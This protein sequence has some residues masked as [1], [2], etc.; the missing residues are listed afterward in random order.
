M[1]K[2]IKKGLGPKDSVFF[3]F[4]FTIQLLV[5]P[6]SRLRKSWHGSSQ[7]GYLLSFLNGKTHSR[8]ILV[9]PRGHKSKHSFLTSARGV[10]KPASFPRNV[11]LP[12]TRLCWTA[13]SSLKFQLVRHGEL[14]LDPR[15][16]LL[17]VPS[18]C[19]FLDTHTISALIS[20][21]FSFLFFSPV[22][23]PMI[24]NICI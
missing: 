4:F 24:S 11:L 23:L 15:L 3:L 21:F 9:Q 5:L 12:H 16:Q 6:S 8:D 20:Y 22:S 7:W 13:Q 14:D 1:H 10:V 18:Y 2:Q 17:F 19:C